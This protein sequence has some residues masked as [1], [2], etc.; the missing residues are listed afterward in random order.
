MWL[1]ERGFGVERAWLLARRR[2]MSAYPLCEG[3]C[4]GE[5]PGFWFCPDVHGVW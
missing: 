4:D 3:V 1:R 2:L 5:W